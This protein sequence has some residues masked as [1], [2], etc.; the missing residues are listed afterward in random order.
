MYLNAYC[1]NRSQDQVNQLRLSWQTARY[2]TLVTGWSLTALSKS[3]QYYTTT[4]SAFGLNNYKYNKR[5]WFV[6]AIALYRR[7]HGTSRLTRSGSVAL[8]LHPSNTMQSETA[9][10]APGAAIWRTG[11]NI[12]VV[13][14]SNL[15]GPLYEN[16]PQNRNYITYGNAVIEQPSNGYRQRLQNIWWN[17]DVLFLPRDAML[18]RYMLS[19]CACLSV[20]HTPISHQNG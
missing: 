1:S 13:F 15:F 17:L 19:S 5:R 4:I 11:R 10:F 6:W 14:G 7:S 9:D 8:S 2:T 20:C 12:C 3:T 16:M 18:A